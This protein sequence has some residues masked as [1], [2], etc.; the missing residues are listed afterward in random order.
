MASLK[1]RIY[2]IPPDSLKYRW[3]APGNARPHTATCG[4]VSVLTVTAEQSRGLTFA[5]Q[6]EFRFGTGSRGNVMVAAC[7]S[8]SAIFSPGEQFKAA[9]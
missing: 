6:T 7:G 8:G 4:A 3:F 1:T 5:D 2:F 9:S